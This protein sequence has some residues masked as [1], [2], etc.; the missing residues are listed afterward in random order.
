MESSLI[1]SL[2]RTFPISSP[3]KKGSINGEVRLKS[4]AFALFFLS[5][6]LW[7][8]SRPYGRKAAKRLAL[9]FIDLD[10]AIEE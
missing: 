1:K 5:L 9:P 4:R 2:K 6:A 8:K 3:L 10:S 7:L